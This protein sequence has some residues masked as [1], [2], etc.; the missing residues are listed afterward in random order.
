MRKLNYKKV[1][2]FLFC[3]TAA[4]GAM[5]LAIK[6]LAFDKKKTVSAYSNDQNYPEADIQTFVKDDTKGGY[7]VSRPVLHIENIDMQL[8][9]YIKKEIKDYE[10]KWKA[11]GGKASSELNLTYTILHFSKQTIT[12]SFDKY[13]Q[14]GGKKQS[15]SRIFT[16]DIPSQKKLSIEDIFAPD[17]DYLSV[18]SD[19]VFEELTES[20]EEGISKSLVKKKTQLKAANFDSFSVLKNTLVFYVKTDEDGDSSKTHTIAI[21]KE[22]FK[23]SLLDSYQSK[24]LNQDRVKEWQ[25]KHVVAK[26][27]VKNEWID[28]SQKVIALTFD[29]GPHPSHTM[30][31]LEALNKYDAHATF[32]VLGSRVQHYPEVLQKMTEQGNEI[33]NHSWDHPQLTRLSKKK[34]KSQIEQT[35]DAIEKATGTE[36]D[37]IRP[38]YGAINDNVREYME[39]MKVTLWDVDPEDWK[40]RSKKKIVG[41]VM[42]K[43]KDGKVILMHDIYQTSAQ[44]AVEIIKQLHD[45]GYQLVTISELEQVKKDRELYGI[46]L[47]E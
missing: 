42:S 33:G 38:P 14:V 24:D 36:P 29:D 21:N 20:K 23:N 6:S 2:I 43:A 31:I 9:A 41:K 3:L 15:G 22:L 7:S 25:P 40:N 39:D 45:K 32:F 10:K 12:I 37:L 11:I 35:Q 27:P 26:L 19:I 8:E 47:Q 44:A 13:E 4:V 18:L 1:F 16:Y 30:S 46:D 5:G 28:P 17:T 34:I